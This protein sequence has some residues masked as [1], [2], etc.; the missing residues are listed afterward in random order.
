MTAHVS[1][2]DV[3][4]PWLRKDIEQ[5]LFFRGGR[6]TRVNSL[7]TFILA[8]FASCIFYAALLPFKES[9]F[10]QM[11]LPRAS[12]SGQAQS[13]LAPLIPF[14]IVFFSSWCLAILF[15]KSRKLKFQRRALAYDVV[16]NDVD[17]VLSAGNVDT[18]IDRIYEIV[19]E[20]R[21]FVLFNRIS[22][23]LANL[24]NLG[25]VADVDEILKSQGENDESGLETSY[26]LLSGFIWAIPVLGFIGTVLGLSSAIGGFGGV[27]ESSDNIET[28]KSGL[29]S[30]TGGLSD[31]FVTT[32]QALVAALFIQ[33][34]LTFLKKSEQ[35][36]LD[37]CGEYC[38]SQIVNRLRI[39]P[40]ERME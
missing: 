40:F 20:P 14:A 7:L 4:L 36:F 1:S 10:A 18:V 8:L 33:I 19:D 12:V 23:A 31:A 22:V 34:L 25:R 26:S 38:V 24:R 5:R 9:A 35:E 37:E 16:P 32:L 15:I 3:P 11:F 17:F 39:M 28:I 13:P 30:V 6:Y 27:L 2:L 21:H 29:K